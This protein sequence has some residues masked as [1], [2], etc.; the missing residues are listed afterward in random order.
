[1]AQQQDRLR[2]LL[3][4]KTLGLLEE[5]EQA[6]LD[7]LLEAEWAHLPAQGQESVDYDTIYKKVEKGM[8]G[9]L[10]RFRVRRLIAA[11]AVLL[12]VAAGA[13]FYFAGNK[14]EP[15][16]LAGA[17]PV[18]NDVAPGSWKATLT[19]DDGTTMTLNRSATGVLADQNKVKVIDKGGELYYE[20]SGKTA[21]TAYNTLTT[22]YGET[23]ALTLSD[24]TRVWLNAGSSLRY[25]VQFAGG[26]RLVT[27]TGEAYFE[28]KHDEQQPFL[29]A[30]PDGSLI[31]DIGTAFNVNAYPDEAIARTT[32]VEGAVA[33]SANGQS[34]NL[35]PGQQARTG[36]GRIT[37]SRDIVMDEIVAWKNG[38]FHFNGTAIKDIM[39][40][41]ARWYGVSVVYKDRPDGQFVAKIP[42]EL[43]LSELLKLLEMTGEVKFRVAG[44]T[45]TVSK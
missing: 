45:V 10:V 5:N 27:I 35:V 28:V 16:K 21:A 33:I 26:E 38:R 12:L 8:S 30:L 23:Y 22:A 15:H 17:G 4:I 24:G 37:V 20:V 7:Q 11:A 43:P 39:T 3:K 32:L 14:T 19:L 41:A 44:K 18:G 31:R 34:V 25:P 6:E 13:W 29:V 9:R 1:M 40:Q 2:Y 42:R 36:N